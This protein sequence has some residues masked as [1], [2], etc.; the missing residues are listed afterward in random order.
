MLGS[1]IDWAL[2]LIM[3]MLRN[4]FEGPETGWLRLVREPEVEEK[5]YINS[6]GGIVYR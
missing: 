5:C 4:L 2:N 3:F 6:P 1:H